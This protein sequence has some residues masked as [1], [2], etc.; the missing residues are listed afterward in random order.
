MKL[1]DPPQGTKL[2][3]EVEENYTLPSLDITPEWSPGSGVTPFETF[4]MSIE[5][6]V[7]VNCAKDLIVFQSKLKFC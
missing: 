5:N 4:N 1:V 3:Y 7:K 2:W 6:Y